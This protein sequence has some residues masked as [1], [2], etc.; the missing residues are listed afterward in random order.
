ML[1]RGE[2]SPRRLEPRGGR[3][4]PAFGSSLRAVAEQPQM[5]RWRA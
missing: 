5:G 4:C 1:W 2:T 3:P